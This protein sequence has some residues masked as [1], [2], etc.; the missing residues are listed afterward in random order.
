M[1]R[2]DSGRIPGGCWMHRLR[3]HFVLAEEC[4]YASCHVEVAYTEHFEVEVEK[5]GQVPRR[6]CIWD[7]ML[8]GCIDKG[9]YILLE[10][11]SLMV[12]NVPPYESEFH[13]RPVS[14]TKSSHTRILW[15]S[16]SLPGAFGSYTMLFRVSV[17]ACPSEDAT[18]SWKKMAISTVAL[19]STKSSVRVPNRLHMASMCS[20]V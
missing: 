16:L 8:D 3:M 1:R 6:G 20:V 10:L 15:S 13:T 9:R 17:S 4:K 19:S 7:G 14:R 11:G 2:V 12:V 5:Q 18:H